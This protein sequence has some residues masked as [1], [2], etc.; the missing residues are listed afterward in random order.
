MLPS[1]PDAK[2]ELELV[3]KSH[4]CYD[5]AGRR[6][7]ITRHAYLT[8]AQDAM[9]TNKSWPHLNTGAVQSTK[10][11]ARSLQRSQLMRS[12]LLGQDALR[13]EHATE[14]SHTAL[15]RANINKAVP[16]S[17]VKLMLLLLIIH[18]GDH[19]PLRIHSRLGYSTVL[20][21]KSP[22][23]YSCICMW[24]AVRP[25][26]MRRLITMQQ[27]LHGLHVTLRT[28]TRQGRWLWLILP[29]CFIQSSCQD[30]RASKE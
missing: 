17:L 4:T 25:C 9:N 6:S 5:T 13:L 30:R 27:R 7:S 21:S 14:T 20:T 16:T 1:Q 28:L 11:T 23:M 24:K 3:W 2:S 22:L 19:T 10:V 29:K 8:T 12:V 18:T 15:S 26:L